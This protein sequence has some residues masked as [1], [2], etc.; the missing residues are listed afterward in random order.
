MIDNDLDLINYLIKN[1]IFASHVKVNSE[2][3]LTEYQNKFID[4][5]VFNKLTEKVKHQ[6][7]V[8]SDFDDNKMIFEFKRIK[9]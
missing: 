1:Q 3:I 8:E 9:K 2:Y 7:H 6:F 4:P 5:S